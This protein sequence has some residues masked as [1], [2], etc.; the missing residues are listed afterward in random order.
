[1]LNPLRAGLLALALA[2]AP[3]CA[4]LQ[5][6]PLPNPIVAAKMPDQTALAVLESYAAILEE[7]ADFVRDPDVPK[8]IKT[9]LG[10]AERAATPSVDVMRTAVS[11]YLRAR[12][13]YELAR[14]KDQ[15]ALER[16]SAALAIAGVRLS[17][18]IAKA[19][20]P[21]AELSVLIAKTR[22]VA[23]EFNR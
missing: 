2:G 4:A 11:T 22:R 20:W 12:A 3:G 16:A 6:P 8:S 14:G 18:A 5:I 19:R 23:P 7:A 10:A 13:D 17:E 21:I 15:S 1:M 9:A